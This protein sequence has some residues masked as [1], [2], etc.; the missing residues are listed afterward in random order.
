MRSNRVNVPVWVLHDGKVGLRNQVIGVAEAVG[1]PFAEKRLETR[2]PWKMLPPA[3]WFNARHAPGRGGDRLLPPWPRLVIAAGGR[4]AAPALAVRDAAEGR[5]LAVQIQDPKIAPRHF[6]LMLIPE[7]D[8]VRAANVMMTRGAVHRV[9]AAKLAEAAEHWRHHLSHLPS[10][11][12]AVLIGGGGAY[13]FTAERM[14]G[15]A[16]D[17]ATLARSGAG[18]MVTPSRRTGEIAERVLR[19][20]L[21]GL[22]AEIW[23]GT[24]DN[25]YFGYLGLA[26]HVLATADSVSMI[27]EASATGKPVHILQLPG[28][29]AKFERFHTAMATAG[30][31]RVFAGRLD[32]WSYPHRDDTAEAGSRI[33]AMMEE[34]G[35][36]K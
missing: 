15:L 24:G 10:P 32:E 2:Y 23:D 9:T 20:R 33:R 25:P 34:R 21:A 31:T 19:A 5:C 6:D 12:I 13:D 3:L 22:P 18:L 14:A 4:A 17:L 27:T 1:L 8:R 7:H 11:R 35:L 16:A 29:S 36:W 26:D 30:V 28:G